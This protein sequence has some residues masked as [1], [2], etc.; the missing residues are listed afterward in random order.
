MKID[1][2]LIIFGLLLIF[3]KVNSLREE[4]ENI[5][6]NFYILKKMEVVSQIYQIKE[7]KMQ[8]LVQY[9]IKHM[10]KKDGII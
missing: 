2:F 10:K 4:N 5:I 7:M 1:I 8:L 3:K 9:I 6:M